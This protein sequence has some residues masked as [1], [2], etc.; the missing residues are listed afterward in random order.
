MGRASSYL[1]IS[2]CLRSSATSLHFIPLCAP[3]LWG[4]HV[5][6]YEIWS[7]SEKNKLTA[8]SLSPALLLYHFSV[9]TLHLVLPHSSLFLRLSCISHITSLP[10]NPFLYL[11]LIYTF[12]MALMRPFFR[13]WNCLLDVCVCMCVCVQWYDGRQRS[14]AGNRM[15]ERCGFMK[16]DLVTE[17]EPFRS[18][19]PQ[20][21]GYGSNSESVL[22][23]DGIW[24]TR[25][26][27]HW[28]LKWNVDFLC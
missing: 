24:D 11:H 13:T 1:S 25:L 6:L 9:A 3:L 17:T 12:L 28:I 27:F 14:W 4:N 8:H 2:L 19:D 10:L 23:R 20:K 16:N 18:K 5:D 26:Q 7:V 15:F 21:L 22:I